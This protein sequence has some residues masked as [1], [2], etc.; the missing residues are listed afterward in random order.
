[1]RIKEISVSIGRTH[2]LGNYESGRIDVSMKAD[3]EQGESPDEV[4]SKLAAK[5]HVALEAR[6]QKSLRV[7][8]S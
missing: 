4:V 3:V 5:V 8:R 6:T 1:M 2:N 7:W